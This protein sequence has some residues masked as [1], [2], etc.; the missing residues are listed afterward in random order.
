MNTTINVRRKV[1]FA[2]FAI[3]GALLCLIGGVAQAEEEENEVSGQSADDR[4][5]RGIPDGGIQISPT[6]FIWTMDDGEI[7]TERINVKNYSDIEQRVTVEVEDFFVG[8]D[9][10]EPK[11][12]VPGEDHPRKARDII[13][14]ITPPDDFTLAPNEAKWVDFTI[15]VPQDQP[16]NGYY[17]GI[18]FKTGGGTDEEGSRI[19]I[20]YRVGSLVIMAVQGD[21]P[22][23]ISG[24]LHNFYPTKKIYWESPATVVAK[25]ENTGNIHYPMYGQIEF[26]KFDKKFHIAEL[27]PQLLYPD[28]PREYMEK[29]MYQWWDF[30]KYTADFSM[31]SENDIVEL[32][33]QTEFWVIPWKGLLVILGGIIGFIIIIKLFIKYV[34][35]GTKPAKKKKKKK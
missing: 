10:M 29:M 21:E 14:W 20:N 3:F 8:A 11:F 33:A 27:K 24:K 35:I 15:A 1:L 5:A 2:S 18:L 19:G 34:H 6:K 32:N 22:M 23:E 31:H 25:V 7:K 12:F 13:N 28:I 16:T 9:G 17:G 26:K 4:A 30:G